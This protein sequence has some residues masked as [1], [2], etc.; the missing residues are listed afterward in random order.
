M[1]VDQEVEVQLVTCESSIGE[2]LHTIT[3]ANTLLVKGLNT[4][5]HNKLTLELY[6]SNPAKCG[7]GKITEIV[8]K[9]KEA[10]ITYAEPGGTYVLMT[11]T[12]VLIAENVFFVVAGRVAEEKQHSVLGHEVEVHL[13]LTCPTTD[14]IT[15]LLT[16]SSTEPQITTSNT[17]LV[18][19]L[20][21]CHT[22]LALKLFFTNKK[23]CGGGNITKIV[24]KKDNAY[25]TFADSKGNTYVLLFFQ[26]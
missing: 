25:V 7:G 11:T 4:Q 24:V 1:I 16:S 21:E 3:T 17:I 9:D 6:F 14:S 15:P 10:Y 5:C 19:G 18:K 26:L 2:Q 22:E 20:K 23:K 12:E 13:V 8:L